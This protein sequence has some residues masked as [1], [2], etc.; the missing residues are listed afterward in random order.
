VLSW[1]RG[2][3]EGENFESEWMARRLL[4]C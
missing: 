4:K 3:G 1:G 2:K